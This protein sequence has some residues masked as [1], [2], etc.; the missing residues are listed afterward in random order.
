MHTHT[1]FGATTTCTSENVRDSVCRPS[2]KCSRVNERKACTRESEGSACVCLCVCAHELIQGEAS[3]NIPGED[4]ACVMLHRRVQNPLSKYIMYFHRKL[5]E[6]DALA[7]CFTNTFSSSPRSLI[8]TP[9]RASGRERYRE[10]PAESRSGEGERTGQRKRKSKR[11]QEK[12]L[13]WPAIGATGHSLALSVNP[14]LRCVCECVCSS[15]ARLV[16]GRHSVS[17]TRR[18]QERERAKPSRCPFVQQFQ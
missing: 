17:R 11:T 7:D 12:A 3:H 1:H 14:V 4:A 6:R 18:Q 2:C 8:T 5:E 10:S 16:I 15:R 13:D 9:N